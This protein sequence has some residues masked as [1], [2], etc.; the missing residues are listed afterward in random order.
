M[1]RF[2]TGDLSISHINDWFTIG[3]PPP[4]RPKAVPCT[5]LG[6][7]ALDPTTGEAA[8]DNCKPFVPNYRRPT[9]G[10][11][12]QNDYAEF[13][14][15]QWV[16]EQL[17][18]EEDDELQDG[19]YK[20][21]AMSELE[22]VTEGVSAVSLPGNA[23]MESEATQV[24][25]NY[26]FEHEYNP[27]L[28]ITQY[29]EAVI[30]T[31]ESNQVTV[32]EG[33][34]GCGKTTQVPQY[35]LEHYV[36]ENRHC[37]I[38]VTQPRRIA[39]MSIARRVCEE[40]KWQLGTIVGYQVGMDKQVSEDTRL[41]FVTTGVL[42]QKLIKTK[43]MNEYTHVILDE[44]HERDL[45]SDFALLVVRK[46]LRTNSRC[47]KVVLMSA[48]I[49]TN[50]FT[51]YFSH[52][53][54][55]RMEPAPVVSIE[56]K[57]FDVEE[58]YLGDLRG[59]GGV[60]A[61]DPENPT[62][63]N[64]LYVLAKKLILHLDDIERKEQGVSEDK[65]AQ[66]RGS[67]LIFLPGLE[68]IHRMEEQLNALITERKILVIPLHSTITT[69]EQI[70]VFT[71]PVAGVRKVI[72]STNIAESSITVPD[73]KYVID[74]ML[75][76]C[77]VCDFETNYQSL[78]LNWASRANAIQRKGRAGR[79]ASGRVYRLITKRFWD[80]Y[81]QDYGIPEMRRCPLE[82]LVLQVKLLDLG[83]PKAILGLA[84]EP[85]NLA[86]IERTV[87]LLKEVGALS[88][89]RSG[90]PNPH[91]G[92]LTFPGKVL[93]SL[94]VDIRLGKLIIL[95]HVFGCLRDCIII[96]AALSLKSIFARPFGKDLDAFRHKKGWA[97][98]SSSDCIA[99]LN[100]FKKWE[101][102]RASGA[103]KIS[104]G[105]EA[106]WCKNNFIQLRRIFDVS[107]L[108]KELIKRL[109][110]F[111]I[112]LPRGH[113]RN[114]P[115]RNPVHDIIILKLILA[116]AFYP[117]YFLQLPS[118]EEDAHRQMSGKD[119][120]TTVMVKRMP[121]NACH[122]SAAVAALFRPC[123]KGKTLHFEESKCFVE[124]ER[125]HMLSNG[126]TQNMVLPAVY[127]AVKMR[128]LRLP[129]SLDVYEAKEENVEA[130]K[131]KNEDTVKERKLKTNRIGTSFDDSEPQFVS[132]P[133]ADKSWIKIYVTE[134]SDGNHLWAHDAEPETFEQLGYLMET[135]NGNSYNTQRRLISV[136]V[137]QYCV[138]P[139]E[140]DTLMYYRARIEAVKGDMVEV[141]FLDYGN[142]ASMP[143]NVLRMIHP[144][145]LKLPFQA[146]ECVLCEVKP[147]YRL[148]NQNRWMP[149]AKERLTELACNR[150]MLAKVFSVV[151][152]VLRIEL[153]S[154][155]G[156]EE[157]NINELLVKEELVERTEEPLASK[158]NHQQRL[159]QAA[160]YHLEEN[161]DESP[162]MPD[163]QDRR[164]FVNVGKVN[165]QGPY[166]PLEVN[167]SGV[168]AIGSIR[169]V[170]IER[171]SV[172]S[173]TLDNEPQA[174]YQ[175]LMVA[176]HVSL[177][178]SGSC[179]IARSTTLMPD[180]KGLPPL[181]CILFA[182]A[183]ELRM[184]KNKSRMTGVLCGLGWDS[185]ANGPA[186]PDH[187][188]EI[189][190]D[191]KITKNDIIKV[192]GL[193]LAINLAIGSPDA[194]TQWGPS[195]VARIQNQAREK[196]LDLFLKRR[197]V[198]TP[199]NFPRSRFWNQLQ[200]DDILWYED[201]TSGESD[202][203]D[204]PKLFEYH[205]GVMVSDEIEE[206]EEM[207]N[208]RRKRR[209]IEELH[210]LASRSSIPFDRPV[211]C[212]LC[213]NTFISPKDVLNHVRSTAH[214]E[215]E[216]TLLR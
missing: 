114:Q 212:E 174:T 55:G 80:M 193:R 147:F 40:R 195:A 2:L 42:L 153:V 96:G 21:G 208:L 47:V 45:D 9:V 41:S 7:R 126:D 178:N 118:D 98:G 116:G 92:D 46:L 188:I 196:I 125:L 19:T 135:I 44:V 160:H 31:I 182:P 189:P 201:P 4:S 37:N 95:G 200:P 33:P 103:F 76:K 14:K 52:P 139:F 140:D 34:T 1:S 57:A 145:L 191:V 190:F 156:S 27:N 206:E 91:D 210:K 134:V 59:L 97:E 150:V 106:D 181:I 26:K 185:L 100:C 54:L 23:L 8:V 51:H 29:Q 74:F 24:Y 113:P 71:K 163:L 162:K 157:V 155:M 171:E 209:E 164:K 213:Q 10:G 69:Q 204:Y 18:L 143:S 133:S 131:T 138:A 85:P 187:D 11:G 82:Y 86:E 205:C 62:V 67:V 216:Q 112:H 183:I 101:E 72:V 159:E 144:D 61:Q 146:F 199:K 168:T 141:F 175:K 73:I 36:K 5:K 90:V 173:V 177:N 184:D 63:E 117:N 132:P 167:F 172:N 107:E 22:S 202:H 129:L 203:Y 12:Q 136:D 32:I 158:I 20:Y 64:E 105:A 161:Y 215:M 176:A 94:P 15:N 16:E 53:V 78:K 152:G 84:L 28:P 39:A 58:Y 65:Y 110:E 13:Y 120:C 60:P 194:I 6:R 25:K 130:L 48:S 102:M 214:R 186:L 170:R 35:I 121:Q 38:I 49:D 115:P 89:L 148:V 197:E 75:T 104:R 137:G 70:R 169:S 179:L 30:S 122:N 99:A 198:I 180:I 88:T 77:L 111:N 211:S 149:Q 192:N 108:V 166:S 66:N 151:G 3:G 87:L 165:L 109:A 127:L 207:E 128:Q 142:V 154:C 79:V 43:N 123:G 83:E 17:G 93:A 50:L 68:Q 124:F 56:G 119:P 81:I